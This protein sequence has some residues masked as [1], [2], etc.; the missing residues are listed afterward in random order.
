MR[1][2]YFEVVALAA[3]FASSDAVL[4]AVDPEPHLESDVT[5][6]LRETDESVIEAS[7]AR[8][9]RAADTVGGLPPIMAT[10]DELKDEQKEEERGGGGVAMEE[11]GK[12]FNVAARKIKSETLTNSAKNIKAKVDAIATKQSQN[13]ANIQLRLLKK[14]LP[15]VK[16][17]P[18]TEEIKPPPSI[19]AIDTAV[20]QTYVQAATTNLAKLV[21]RAKADVDAAYK[22]LAE[23]ASKG[24]AEAPTYARGFVSAAHKQVA[25]VATIALASI[26]TRPR[27]A[28]AAAYDVVSSTARG[29]IAA[30]P[31]RAK[32]IVAST[33]NGF[34]NLAAAAK[35][36]MPNNP[37]PASFTDKL[38]SMVNLGKSKAP[39][40]KPLGPTKEP[41]KIA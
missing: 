16:N 8:L 17:F 14:V 35:E 29:A 41:I 6:V 19:A 23:T 27:A 25:D 36:R 34:S 32:D 5:L 20:P 2:L 12:L 37:L 1:L 13:L 3:A 22:G 31:T 40:E 11:A 26:P 33:Y 38:R 7:G 18:K 28:V 10:E 15:L 24:I 9:L 4:T 39:A 21:G 30:T